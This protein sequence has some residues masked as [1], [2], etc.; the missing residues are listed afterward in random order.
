MLHF[1]CQPTTFKKC[2]KQKITDCEFK[3][4]AIENT[5]AM[6]YMFIKHYFDKFK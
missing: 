3:F 2:L 1:A 4:S 5:P 6:E